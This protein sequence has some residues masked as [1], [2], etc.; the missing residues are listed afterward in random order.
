[1]KSLKLSLLSILIIILLTLSLTAC[2]NNNEETTEA[3][4]ETVVEN[5]TENKLETTVEEDSSTS[6]ENNTQDNNSDYSETATE[7]ETKIQEATYKDLYAD[8]LKKNGKPYFELIYIDNDN[9]PE[10][11]C[12]SGSAHLDQVSLY[13]VY[14]EK[15]VSLGKFGVY[16]S[17][18]YAKKKNR[19]FGYTGMEENSKLDAKYTY[20]ISGGKI[21]HA[22]D[23][24]GYKRILAGIDG[25][26]YKNSKK[27]ISKVLG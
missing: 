8:F 15:V 26:Y 1:M 14:D 13:T 27:N 6:E 2:G 25:N 18:V 4:S 16:G 10:L 12:F 19:I 3:I 22:P 5:T 24:D 20:M 23:S 7:A 11:A 21:V 9:I 17:M